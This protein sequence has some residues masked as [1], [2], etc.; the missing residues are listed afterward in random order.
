[1][2]KISACLMPHQRERKK[3]DMLYL[4]FS[5]LNTSDCWLFAIGSL[6]VFLLLY[7]RMEPACLSVGTHSVWERRSN[8]CDHHAPLCSRTFERAPRHSLHPGVGGDC[9]RSSCLPLVPPSHNSRGA[10][11]TG[12]LASHLCVVLCLLHVQ[13]H[14]PAFHVLLPPRVHPN[15]LHRSGPE[16]SFPLRC[17]FS[18]RCGQAWV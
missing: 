15:F 5:V 17:G 12:V 14:L 3:K 7:F 6:C 4:D 11:V 10:K 9:V 13:R 2:V 1:M 16:R 8:S 18:T